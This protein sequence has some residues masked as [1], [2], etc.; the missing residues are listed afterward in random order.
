MAHDVFISHSSKDKVMAD[1]ICAGLEARGIRCWIAPRDVL[2][3]VEWTKSIVEAISNCKLFLLVLTDNSNRSLQAV[4]E[5]DCALN[6]ERIVLPF[7]LEDVKPTGSMEYYLSSIHWL[8]ALTPPLESH[9]DHLAAY[10]GRIIQTPVIKDEAKPVVPAIPVVRVKPE[11]PAP[12]ME[13]KRNL[14]W[15]WLS[16]AG[17]L[18]AAVIAGGIFFKDELFARPEPTDTMSM[19][20]LTPTSTDTPLLP[21]ETLV[22]TEVVTATPAILNGI[23]T[24]NANC[25]ESANEGTTN[26]KILM[27]GDEVVILGKSADGN[28]LNIE[29]VNDTGQN[30]CN[31]TILVTDCWLKIDNNI[32]IGGSVDPLPVFTPR[33][34]AL[35]WWYGEVYCTNF[36]GDY[37]NVNYN[38]L[39][40]ELLSVVSQYQKDGVTCT[41]RTFRGCK[42]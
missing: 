34:A 42:Y 36:A 30:Y 26:R 2:P 29:F 8:D 33:P 13:K 10:I 5:V 6:H 7:R 11:P 35:A 17:I 21:T 41:Y 38:E 16:I 15:L 28:W 23:I 14:I 32:Q 9:I 18:L 27:T 37:D 20:E 39:V 1:A 12:A 25:W 22:P 40:K 4:K 3:G 31:T 19:A 24:A